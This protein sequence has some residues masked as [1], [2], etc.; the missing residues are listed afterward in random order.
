M[1]GVKSYG[2]GTPFTPGGKRE[3]AETDEQ[4]LVREIKEELSVDL[5]PSTLKYLQTFTAQAYGKP[6][7][8]MVEIKCY[9]ADFA[10]EFKPGAEIESLEWLT[11]ADMPRL[12][13]PF[14]KVLTWLR[15][16][17]LID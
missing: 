13:I 6:E 17:D 1:L 7:G 14:Q 11:T 8:V 12:G 15:E 2:K 3:G 16:K 10:G 5:A 4:A 9:S